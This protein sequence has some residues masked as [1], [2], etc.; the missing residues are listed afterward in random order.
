M[1]TTR[2]ERREKVTWSCGHVVVWSWSCVGDDAKVWSC[3]RGEGRWYS[4]SKLQLGPITQSTQLRRHPDA[5]FFVSFKTTLF[6]KLQLSTSGA[7]NRRLATTTTTTMSTGNSDQLL[8]F[9]E[10]ERSELPTTTSERTSERANFRPLP[11]VGSYNKYFLL[12]Q[13]LCI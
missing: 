10:S 12:A 2:E 5:M 11:F 1:T 9:R 6:F 7:D 13:Q 3:G 8:T 4:G